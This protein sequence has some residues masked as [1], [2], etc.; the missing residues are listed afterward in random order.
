MNWN[1][2][3]VDH[4]VSGGLTLILA[5]GAI[6]LEMQADGA[7]EWLI[8]LTGLAAGFYF[9]GRVNGLYN[10]SQARRS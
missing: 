2:D 6:G 8:G 7:P 5:L 9:R 10:S 1:I 4:L 3:L